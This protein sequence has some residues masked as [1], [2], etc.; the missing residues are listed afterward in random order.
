MRFSPG[1]NCCGGGCGTI[2]VTVRACNSPQPLLSGATVTIK[3]DEGA[4]VGSGTTDAT[5]VVEVAIAEAATY[6]IT[7]AKSGLTT[8]ALELAA[9]CT[10]NSKTIYLWRGVGGTIHGCSSGFSGSEL[11]GVTVTATSGASTYSTTSNPDGTYALYL[12]DAGTYT[13]SFSK[14]RFITQSHSVS[15]TECG[16]ALNVDMLPA[17]GYRCINWGGANFCN[18]P[19]PETLFLTDPDYGAVT[20][21][22]DAGIGTGYWTGTKAVSY[23]GGCSDCPPANIT[24][25]YFLARVVSSITGALSIS[26]PSSFGANSCPG[27]PGIGTATNFAGN[28]L[29]CPPAFLGTFSLNPGGSDQLYCADGTFTVTE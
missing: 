19:L 8:A 21:T 18:T 29:A 24:V 27:G 5:G 10:V 28:T 1:C 17:A 6:T 7:V 3:D 4:V 25:S 13:V 20:L 16:T 22:Y 12:G 2:R 23:P 26:F 14:A 9:T 15:I 11:G